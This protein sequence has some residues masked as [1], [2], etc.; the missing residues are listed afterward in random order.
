M[1][2]LTVG[3]QFP[4]DRLVRAVDEALGRSALREEVFAQVGRGGYRPRHMEWVETLEREVFAERVAGARAL[5]GH[6]GMG[7]I[8]MALEAGKPLLVMPRLHRYREIVNDHQVATARKFGELGHVLVACDEKEIPA[9]LA[10]LDSF[11]PVP[12]HANPAGIVARLEAFLDE[13]ANGRRKNP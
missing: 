12:R 6:A 8:L 3:T 10:A 13:I 7:T 9:R 11:V 2:F 1:I 4:F 5:I